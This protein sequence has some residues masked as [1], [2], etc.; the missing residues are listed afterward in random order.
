MNDK[1]NGVFYRSKNKFDREDK[2][3]SR[4]SDC[5]YNEADVHFH[6]GFDA[7]DIG[8]KKKLPQGRLFYGGLT[9]ARKPASTHLAQMTAQFFLR[10]RSANR[11]S[12]CEFTHVI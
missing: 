7:H 12:T 5:R 10:R 6:T 2:A 9:E 1:S 11:I 8:R 3:L 4:H